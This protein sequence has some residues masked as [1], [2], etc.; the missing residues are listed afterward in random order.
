LYF[1][2][3][4]DSIQLIAEKFLST[5][6]DIVEENELE[7]A[8]AIYP[9]QILSIPSYIITPTFGPSPTPTIKVTPEPTATVTPQG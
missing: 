2:L 5:I 9:G 7:D 1:V 3:P 4:G 6:D 8:A